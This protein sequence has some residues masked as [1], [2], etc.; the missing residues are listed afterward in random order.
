MIKSKPKLPTLLALI[1][2]ITGLVVGMYFLRN[3]QSVNIGASSNATPKNVRFS[4]ITD[5]SITI[6]WTTD[7]ESNGFIKW[8]TAPNLLNKTVIEDEIKKEYV[9][10]INI[11][12]IDPN[13]NIYFKITS[14]DKEYDNN[15]ISW[16][17]K[18]LSDA[19][20][21]NQGL[22]A[23]GSVLKS[24]G[25]SPA[26]AIVYVTVNGSLFSGITSEQGTYIVPVPSSNP[27]L[28]DSTPIDIT[29]INGL[30]E[31][32]QAIIYKNSLRE[33][34]T[35]MLGRTYDFRSLTTTTSSDQPKGSV[36]I[37]E[38]TERSSRF[39]VQ[40]EER[41]STNIDVTLD[42]INDGE[43]INTT[44][45]EF[46]GVGPEK[47]DIQVSVHSSEL[48][49]VALTTDSNGKWKWSPPNNLEPGQ[50]SVT[51]SWRDA[52]GILQTITKSFVVSAAEGPA[53][54]TTPSGTLATPK[55]TILPTI[56]PAKSTPIATNKP[57]PETGSLT[58]TIGLFIMGIG[59]LL[60][61]IF[62]WNKQDA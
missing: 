41:S 1:I 49:E 5:S 28:S 16:S 50:H 39:E 45:P 11:T 46:F 57:T 48:Q 54:E 21:D 35:M 12:G 22:V 38:R 9:H 26:K 58:P 53:F 59:V 23:L 7:I 4:N 55:P 44:D 62:V 3:K 29:I 2:L 24:D 40:R 18:T 25:S 60:S 42:S 14:G 52:T 8:G 17:S 56:T 33:I 34:P 20:Q 61:S 13:S 43:I 27:S 30:G 6:T 36:S 47:M 15:G 19:S 32:S 31:T 51:L 10:N 37:P